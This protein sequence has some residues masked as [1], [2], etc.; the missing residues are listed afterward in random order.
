MPRGV[1]RRLIPAISSMREAAADM[2]KE[3]YEKSSTQKS[4]FPHASNDGK[5]VDHD[6]ANALK[7]NLSGLSDLV[8]AK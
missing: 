8:E 6:G 7:H 3:E 4:K 2:Q 1:I 5:V